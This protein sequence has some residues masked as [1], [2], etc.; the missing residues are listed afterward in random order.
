M[1][2]GVGRA[3]FT[4]AGLIAIFALRLDL[5]IE[6]LGRKLER[7]GIEQPD[8]FAGWPLVASDVDARVTFRMGADSYAGRP[9]GHNGQAWAL[10]REELAVRCVET[11]RWTIQVMTSRRPLDRFR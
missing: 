1:F 10:G 2:V 7:F 5:R 8:M 11:L 4:V 9:R 6:R 3:L